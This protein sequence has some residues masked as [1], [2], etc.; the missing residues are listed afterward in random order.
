MHWTW[1]VLSFA[2][3]FAATMAAALWLLWHF[4]PK[5]GYPRRMG[6]VLVLGTIGAAIALACWMVLD[7]PRTIGCPTGYDKQGAYSDC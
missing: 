1:I 7:P 2:F 3:V 6:Q 4:E 5:E